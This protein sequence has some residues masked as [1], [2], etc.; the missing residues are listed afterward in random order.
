MSIRVFETNII[1]GQRIFDHRIINVLII[2]GRIAVFDPTFSS[3]LHDNFERLDESCLFLSGF[4]VLFK[5]VIRVIV[6]IVIF[7]VCLSLF[8]KNCNSVC[9][10]LSLFELSVYIIHLY[11]LSLLCILSPNTPFF[12]RLV[13]NFN[14]SDIV[15]RRIVFCDIRETLSSKSIC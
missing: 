15:G 14:L 7:R 8:F 3:L 2:D 11:L 10:S 9:L 6:F 13:L 5:I 4:G 12:T 1:F